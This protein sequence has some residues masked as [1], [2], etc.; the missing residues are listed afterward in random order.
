MTSVSGN[1][2]GNVTGDVSGSVS[3]NVPG[4]PEKTESVPMPVTAEGCAEAYRA[5]ALERRAAAQRLA[6][7]ELQIGWGR[8]GLAAVF[9]VLLWAAYHRSAPGWTLVVPVLAFLL[10]AQVHSR[11]AE[12]RG[13]A[14]RAIA[15]YENGLARVED[16]WAHAA[17]TQKEPRGPYAGSLFAADLDL[18]GP[19]SLFALLSTARTRV[20]EDTLAGWLLQPAA[21]GVIAER[22]EAVRELRPRV[23]LREAMAVLAP[24]PGGRTVLAPVPGGRTVL[25]PVPGG[26][27]V[28]APVP[29][30]RTVLAHKFGAKANTAQTDRAARQ[31]QVG[32]RATEAGVGSRANHDALF[33]WAEAPQRLADGLAGGSIRLLAA[34]LALMTGAALVAWVAGHSVGWLVALLVVDRLVIYAHRRPLEAIFEGAGAA[35]ADLDLLAALLGRLEREEFTAPMLVELAGQLRDG[36]GGAGADAA[37]P[38]AGAALRAASDAIAAL[39]SVGN[40]IDSREN[41]LIRFLNIPLLYSVQV[42]YAAEAWRAKHGSAVR[43]WLGA[44]AAFEALV[45]IA[46]YSYEHPGDVFPELVAGPAGS[47]AAEVGADAALFDAEAL[48]H[49]LLPVGRCVRNRLRLGGEAP[50]MLISGSNMS[51][52]STLLRAVGLNTVLAMAGAP[53]RAERLRMTR[54]GVGASILVNDSLADGSSRFYAEITRLRAI[55]D[56]ALPDSSGDLPPLL[57]LLDELLEGTNSRDRQVGATGILRT[58]AAR[59]AIGIATTH[60]LALTTVQADAPE[61]GMAGEGMVPPRNMHL[62]DAVVDG[63]MAFDYTLREGV[64]TRSNGVELMRMVG[65]DV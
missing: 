62:E 48:G 6:A 19:V 31:E 61:G 30:R 11:V 20:G 32:G 52:K 41:L 2:S 53:V 25:A 43:A 27:T 29:G 10:L 58:L 57:F 50:V 59:G 64:V 23:G 13:A 34:V 56:R 63:T 16:Q 65:L 46:N 55:C 5:R 18:F 42:A 17:F 26:R 9:G 51:G 35:L 47:S 22:Q 33:D 12:Q 40:L 45:S 21:A 3:G 28:L 1:V 24:V 7:R 37:E 38:R 54:L 14:A 36:T 49:P 15:F 60:D 8:L 44:L 39:R 4:N